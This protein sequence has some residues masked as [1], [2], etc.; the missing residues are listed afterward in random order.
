MGI[1][2]VR[3][4]SVR[5]PDDRYQREA[6]SAIKSLDSPGIRKVTVAN[7]TLGVATVNVPHQLSKIPVGWLVIDKNAQADVWR[8]TTVNQTNDTIPLK[9]SATVV[10]TLQFW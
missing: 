3:L 4:P 9:A 2:T 10:V 7:V 8:D 5:D 6:R 1:P